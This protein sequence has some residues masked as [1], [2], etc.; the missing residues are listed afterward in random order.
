MFQTKRTMTRR[1]ILFLVYPCAILFSNTTSLLQILIAHGGGKMPHPRCV[2]HLDS[3]NNCNV[4]IVAIA[5]DELN[6][7][8]ELGT[9]HVPHDDTEKIKE[10]S[11][12]KTLFTK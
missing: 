6:S 1:E 3:G 11:S 12:F 7:R 9:A 5:I 8:A 10:N 2:V 4:S